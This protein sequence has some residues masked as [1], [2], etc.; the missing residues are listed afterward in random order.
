MANNP[1]HMDNLTSS[2]GFTTDTA[3]INGK[4]GAIAK[5]RADRLNVRLAKA[6]SFID[7]QNLR[8]DKRDFRLLWKKR[9]TGMIESPIN[10]DLRTQG[11]LRIEL[12][13]DLKILIEKMR[14]IRYCGSD[15][16][17]VL[18]I[19]NNPL[20]ALTKPEVV[21]KAQAEVWD[22]REGKSVQESK[23]SGSLQTTNI[24]KIIKDDIKRSGDE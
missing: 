13:E 11:E 20:L 5:G 8:K 7:K 3:S 18:A 21:I 6:A 23:L 16:L 14:I 24:T 19:A 17:T 4:K 9:N 15:A 12:R 10:N 2:D 1:N 22:R